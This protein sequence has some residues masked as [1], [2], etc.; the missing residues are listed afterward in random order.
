[1]SDRWQAYSGLTA[2]A[3]TSESSDDNPLNI[4]KEQADAIREWVMRGGH[5]IVVL[6]NVAQNWIAQPG[7][8][9]ADIMPAVKITRTRGVHLD[10]YRSL[11]TR[12]PEVE[13]P[14]PSVVQTFAPMT[15]G[16]WSPDAVP[17]M[18]GPDGV[19]KDTVVVRRLVGDG[20]VTVV[21]L[22]FAAPKIH[23]KSHAF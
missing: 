16:A 9:L 23:L 20:M 10:K 12:D 1:L 14:N 15:E 6:P 11:F 22:D 18:S 19:E 13:L 2:L 21:G 5:F 7:N 3:W 4:R 17:I 8:P